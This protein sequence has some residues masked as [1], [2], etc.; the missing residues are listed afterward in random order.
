MG[1]HRRAED[2]DDADPY[3][4]K[5]I[6]RSAPK[7]VRTI[8]PRLGRYVLI[9]ILAIFTF[10]VFKSIGAARFTAQ[11]VKKNDGCLPNPKPAAMPQELIDKCKGIADAAT[12]S[13]PEFTN[14]VI[15]FIILW[16]AHTLLRNT[17]TAKHWYSRQFLGGIA[18]LVLSVIT[19]VA[20][21]VWLFYV[22]I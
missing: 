16:I 1:S 8:S 20:T 11:Y 19:G 2:I 3:D 9:A 15:F 6:K 21:V 12:S 5:Q 18:W 7:K 10:I 14:W 13:M 22:F 4:D 17:I